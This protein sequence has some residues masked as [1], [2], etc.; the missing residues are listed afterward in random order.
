M[1]SECMGVCT[2]VLRAG[3]VSL[4]RLCVSLNGSL[5]I[6]YIF[7]AVSLLLEERMEGDNQ[8]SESQSAAVFPPQGTCDAVHSLPSYSMMY[9]GSR[10]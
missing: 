3:S 7:S 8:S 1:R 9:T 5:I 10:C 2:Y 6:I 4:Q